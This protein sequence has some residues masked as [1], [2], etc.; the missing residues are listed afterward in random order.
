MPS[1]TAIGL[2]AGLVHKLPLAIASAKGGTTPGGATAP[3]DAALVNGNPGDGIPDRYPEY[4]GI[5]ANLRVI[6]MHG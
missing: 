3:N 5:K 1:N 4:D 6:G 2:N